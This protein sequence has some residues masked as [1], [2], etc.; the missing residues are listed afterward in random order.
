MDFALLK[1]CLAPSFVQLE[2]DR[3]IDDQPGRPSP[4][5]L[6]WW[7]EDA[8][9]SS[10]GEK[11][12]LNPWEAQYLQ[13]GVGQCE[14]A[15]IA[16]SKAI[17][18]WKHA[19]WQSRS[20][21]CVELVWD[22]IG[23]LL[24]IFN[25]ATIESVKCWY[26][27]V[28][29]AGCCLTLHSCIHTTPSLKCNAASTARTPTCRSLSVSSH[30]KAVWS[31]SSLPYT[32][33]GASLPWHKRV[34]DIISTHR[35]D[36]ARFSLWHRERGQADAFHDADGQEVSHQMTSWYPYFCCI[37]SWHRYQ[38]AHAHLYAGN[39]TLWLAP[40]VAIYYQQI[41]VATATMH[42]LSFVKR[43]PTSRLKMFLRK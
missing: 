19:W 5:L 6:L 3:V 12:C 27:W 40:R 20:G 42:E 13:L 10:W 22:R 16:A 39:L 31:V 24:R 29:A 37:R 36:W 23:R 28:P 25:A 17:P 41:T 38:H 32:Q 15:S 30:R 4:A 1:G 26:V 18:P 33:T 9:E 14:S 7:H 8:W 35:W 34:L 2:A 43:G 11:E 21:T